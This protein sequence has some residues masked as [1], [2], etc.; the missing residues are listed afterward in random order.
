MDQLHHAPRL[1]DRVVIMPL[2]HLV[3]DLDDHVSI[4]LAAQPVHRVIHRRADTCRG[5]GAIRGRKD[6]VLAKVKELQQDDHTQAVA[7]LD[8]PRQALRIPF[9]QRAIRVEPRVVIE[10]AMPVGPRPGAAVPL[11]DPGLAV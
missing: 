11:G 10:I 5:A 1:E 9:V 6:G 4:T 3:G 8:G 2:H 7:A